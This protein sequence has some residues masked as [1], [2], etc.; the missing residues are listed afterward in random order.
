ML[1]ARTWET[2]VKHDAGRWELLAS[3][4]NSSRVLSL[5][6]VKQSAPA[7]APLGAAPDA[8]GYGSAK[9]V[10]SWHDTF[11]IVPQREPTVAGGPPGPGG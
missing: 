4:T 7:L 1:L 11:P 3:S 2:D 8:A 9:P 6:A 10:N 5:L